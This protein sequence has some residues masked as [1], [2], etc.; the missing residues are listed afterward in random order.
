MFLAGN[1][2]KSNKFSPEDMLKQL[3]KHAENSE[4]EADNIP[5][6]QQIKSWISRFNHHHKK[7][8][9]GVASTSSN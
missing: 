1:I 7:Q 9:A 4:I 2:E 6:L 3:E 8:A 5:T